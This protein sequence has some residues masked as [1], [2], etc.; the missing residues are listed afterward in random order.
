MRPALL[1]LPSVL[2]GCLLA[3]I[4]APSSAVAEDPDRPSTAVLR[5]VVSDGGDARLAGAVERVLRARLDGL[6]V[7]DVASTPALGLSDLQLAVG[8]VGESDACLEAVAEQVGVDALLLSTLDGADDTR[9][10][11]VT[12]FDARRGR[13]DAAIQREAGPGAGNRILEGIDGLLRELFDLPIPDDPAAAPSLA[14]GLEA[15]DA[16]QSETGGP[17]ALPFVL[18]GVGVAGLAT[19]AALGFVAR[20]TE[21]DYAGMPV[22]T[23]ADAER[24]GHLLDKS[25]RQARA[26]YAMLG[27]GG[28]LA[29]GGLILH[30]VMRNRESEEPPDLAV[31]PSL[32]PGG[33][34]LHVAGRF[35]GDP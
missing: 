3:V 25:R 11:T 34:G 6:D 5:P 28:A 26:A 32:G 31:L 9:V 15:T 29:V 35:G 30:F 13:R 23:A 7:V 17:S 16:D 14:S 10:L 24:A 21:N 19:G 27:V 20:R 2:A 8:C 33:A 22:D 18:A 1:R 4:V 12:F